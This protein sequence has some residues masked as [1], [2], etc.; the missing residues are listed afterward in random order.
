MVN[1]DWKAK[2][3]NMKIRVSEQTVQ[4]LRT[5]KT[6]ANNVAAYNKNGGD[7]QTREAMNRFYGTARVS[8]ALGGGLTT[9]KSPES[10]AVKKGSSTVGPKVNP[11]IN[12]KKPSTRTNVK[13]LKQ[14]A[15]PSVASSTGN[16]IKN[17]LLGIDD[18]S[19]IGSE[20][21]K[22]HWWDAAKSYGTGVLELGTTVAAIVAAVPTGGASLGAKA[23]IVAGRQL[24][25]QAIKTA[26]SQAGKQS[27]KGIAKSAVKTVA[28]GSVRKGGRNV[29][30]AAGKVVHPI[31]T[32]RGVTSTVGRAVVKNNMNTAARTALRSAAKN[33]TEA[34]A[35][36]VASSA[37]AKSAKESVATI[38]KKYSSSATKVGA[39]TS[40]RGAAGATRA[41][42]NRA[43][44]A[45][46]LAKSERGSA[47][48]AKGA[49]RKA[50]SQVAKELA[51]RTAKRAG[52]KAT[53]KV[54][55]KVATRGQVAHVAVAINS[56]GRK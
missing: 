12:T 41:A 2:N 30:K 36:S 56:K 9:S 48:A 1:A 13:T 16:F 19:K 43:T 15:R 24:G 54:V 22:G 10:S 11:T 32:T 21:S 44:K 33:S 45:A 4:K 3:Y 53:K 6:F 55:R 40:S 42:K 47:L 29:A 25:K 8:K 34:S 31:R 50:E 49:L 35:R 17:E 26:V 27:A 14:P 20:I 18:F 38:S 51:T 52:A 23:A 7:A 28:T 39:R 46:A 37:A 5:G